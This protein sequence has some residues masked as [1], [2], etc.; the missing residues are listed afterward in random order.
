MAETPDTPENTETSDPTP[1]EAMGAAEGTDVEAAA[2]DAAE[3]EGV[4]A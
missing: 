4:A 3:T 2:T 1:D